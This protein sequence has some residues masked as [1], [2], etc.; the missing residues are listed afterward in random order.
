[1]KEAPPDRFIHYIHLKVIFDEGPQVIWAFNSE[2][3]QRI[4]W[5]ALTESFHS[6][7]SCGKTDFLALTS[8]KIK[9]SNR[10]DIECY[11]IQTVSYSAKDIWIQVIAF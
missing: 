11:I 3:I 10:I 1:M 5:H 9:N 4:E 8:I 2:G 7:W 6:I